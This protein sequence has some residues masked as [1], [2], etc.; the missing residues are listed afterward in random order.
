MKRIAA[1]LLCVMLLW[2]AAG[3]G[4]EDEWGDDHEEVD[5]PVVPV[6]KITSDTSVFEEYGGTITIEPDELSDR[7][8]DGE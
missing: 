3:C 8:S 6:G 1:A 2:A 4:S 5:I 7:K